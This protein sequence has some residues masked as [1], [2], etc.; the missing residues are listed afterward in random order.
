MTSNFAAPSATDF[1]HG[2]STIP[3]IHELQ[4][5]NSKARNGDL[6][7]ESANIKIKP[8]L[9]LVRLDTGDLLDELVPSL[10]LLASHIYSF[11]SVGEYVLFKKLYESFDELNNLRLRLTHNLLTRSEQA[12]AKKQV[13]LLL[14]NISKFLSSKGVNRFDKST[15]SQLKHDSSGYQSIT[16]RDVN[17]GEL[18]DY[19]NA[20]LAQQP[21]PKLIAANQ[22]TAALA[23]NFPVNENLDIELK[24][25]R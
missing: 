24:P 10:A 19:Q 23:P 8:P 20:D 11:Y 16:A 1:E 15:G 18:Y 6:L 12:L 17:S 7:D 14:T 4:Q 22:L 25:K 3:S 5:S 13:S 9:P 21:I 2:Q